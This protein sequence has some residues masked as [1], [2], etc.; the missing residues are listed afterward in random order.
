MPF[1]LNGIGTHY[2]GSSNRSARVDVCEFCKRSTTLASYDTREFFCILY[3]P[4]IP[5]AKYRIID[6]CS[7]CRRHR[8]LS[9]KEFTAKLEA[10]L[11]PLRE[12][13]KRSPQDPQ[14]HFALV[15]T[16]IGWE[17]RPEAERELQVAMTR[18]PQNVELI[19]LSAQLAVDRVDYASA[20]PLY[21]RACT[22]D[23]QSSAAT[24]GHGWLLHRMERYEQAIPILQ[25]SVSQEPGKAGAL[26]LLGTSYMKC[27][28]WVEALNTFQQLLALVPA[29]Q[30]DKKFLRMIREC[31]QRLGYEL[32]DAE[33][34]AGRSWW[35]FS[36]KTKQP[37]LQSAPTLVRPSLRY[38]GIAILVLAVIG[39][40]FAAWDRRSNI[41]LFVDSGLDRP[42]QVELDG[43][44]FDIPPKSSRKQILKEGAHTL[45]VRETGGKEIERL[46]FDV[47]E[48]GIFDAVMHDRFFVYDVA[49]LNVYRRATYGY[50]S[51]AENSTY[52]EELIG[53][54]KFFEQRDVDYPFQSPPATID[55]DSNT[56]VVKKVAFNPAEDIDLSTYALLLLGRGKKDEAKAAIERAAANAPC[57]TRTRRRQVQLAGIMGTPDAASAVAH[58]WMADCA[59][60][61]LEAQRAY[62]DI[63]TAAGRQDAMR[64][65]Y[66]KLLA[67]APDS[68]KAHYLYGRVVADPAAATAEYQQAIAH[69]PNLAWARIA[70]GRSYEQ[71]ERH[72]DAIRELSAALEMK[73]RDSSAVMDYAMA[74]IAKGTP[75]EAV[76]KV[77]EARKANPKERA[78]V[79][80]RWLLA[81]ATSDWATAAKMQKILGPLEGSASAWLRKAKLMRMQNAPGIDQEID[82]AAQTKQLRGLAAKMRAARLID[83][84]DFAASA[85][86][87]AKA[88][89]DI[90]P[91]VA[92][93]LQ[94]YAAGGALLQ[95]NAPLATTILDQADKSL[96]GA[97]SASEVRLAAAVVGGL[98][99]SKS[100]DAVMAVA[101]ESNAIAHGW[102]V[103][104]VRAAVAKDRVRA[105]E[106]LAHCA[107]AASDLEFPYLE[108]KAMAGSVSGRVP[109][110]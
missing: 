52:A 63:N 27:S 57:D 46:T 2:Y 89:D 15:R 98:R 13:V 60:D 97:E 8:R 96:A 55:I 83:K 9:S 17:M 110:I 51:N 37:K 45:V 74:A 104:A 103:A 30:D 21:E 70:L 72:D 69:D 29:Y 23:P 4:L 33:R 10:T 85:A 26:Y 90:D 92:A 95:G 22:I 11:A 43:G 31:K 50:A 100:A 86:A 25:R 58:R 19:L 28:R 108:A 77:E 49:G 68:G 76:T 81:L 64:Q 93:L 53:M 91:G 65:E 44:K 20:L 59:T 42:V 66:G 101:R 82:R 6:F 102:F 7:S 94:A 109:A 88:G 67:A 18:F 32:T 54:K 56:S 5:I 79:D 84:G 105:A 36:R 41:E 14:A 99:G 61:D 75:D 40:I 47:A 16:L 62:Q 3:I 78:A 34:R 107:R 48:M 87:V 71:M 73:G 24:Y 39:G 12:A 80:A 38:A 106:C 35:P 1:T